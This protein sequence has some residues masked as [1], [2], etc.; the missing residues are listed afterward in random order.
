L[1][2]DPI[3]Y[4]DPLGLERAP[5]P[6][7]WTDGWKPHDLSKCATAECAAGILPTPRPASDTAQ[8]EFKCNV[9]YQPGCTAAGIGT[10]IAT[11]PMGGAIVGGGCVGVKYLV[12]KTYCK[13]S[14]DAKD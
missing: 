3:S 4:A 14:C 7:W 9:K 6:K 12:C 11:T 1:Q 5:M 13:N 8:C 2:S 10:G